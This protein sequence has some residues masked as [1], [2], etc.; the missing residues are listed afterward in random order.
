MFEKVHL[1]TSPVIYRTIS[2]AQSV[3]QFDPFIHLT[4]D[5]T[6]RI[7][8]HMSIVSS[9]RF[10]LFFPFSIRRVKMKHFLNKLIQLSL[11]HSRL[12]RGDIKI[13][14]RTKGREQ[15][16]LDVERGRKKCSRSIEAMKRAHRVINNQ[17]KGIKNV[18]HCR[19]LNGLIKHWQER[20]QWNRLN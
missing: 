4:T 17:F 1:S 9:S 18:P 3:L 7:R 16:A 13:T 8:F 5:S 2:H 11:T 12:H 15:V 20:H 10:C 14:S 6:D 19:A